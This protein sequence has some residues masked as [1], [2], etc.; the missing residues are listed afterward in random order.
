VEFVKPLIYRN[1]AP[2]AAAHR[3]QDGGKQVTE[4]SHEADETDNG[5]Y[6]SLDVCVRGAALLRLV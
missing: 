5:C 4:K 1:G 2:P 6:W 3:F